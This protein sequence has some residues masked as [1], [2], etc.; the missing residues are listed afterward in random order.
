MSRLTPP[1][2]YLFWVMWPCFIS[3]A[4]W[5]Q[6][7]THCSCMYVLY[8]TNALH[9]IDT[10]CRRKLLN[11]FIPGLY[12]VASCCL[13]LSEGQMHPSPASCDLKLTFCWLVMNAKIT[14]V[15]WRI[16]LYTLFIHVSLLR[17]LYASTHTWRNAMYV[18]WLSNQAKSQGTLNGEDN[19]MFWMEMI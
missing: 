19:K 16:I 15:T 2:H 8:T 11:K 17:P 18:F 12:T 3:W 4:L 13:T 6:L 10:W 14:H 7:H 5:S 1:P 9:K